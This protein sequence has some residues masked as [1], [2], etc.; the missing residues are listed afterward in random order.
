MAQ[1]SLKVATVSMEELF[2]DFH[3]TATVQREIN[4][5]RA[6][7]QKDNNQRLAAIR[8]IDEKLQENRGKLGEKGLGESERS[9]LMTESRELQQDGKQKERE[10]SEFLNRRN[11]DL[12]SKM[13]K[14]MRSILADIERA[15]QDRARSGNYDYILDSSGKSSQGVPFVLHARETTDLTETILKEI[16]ADKPAGK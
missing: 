7:I 13:G 8:E 15:V 12:N 3:E 11:K 4:I 5:E 10:R 16:N 14:R 6:R 2:N 9:Q 1:R